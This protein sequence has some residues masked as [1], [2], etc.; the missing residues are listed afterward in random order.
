MD[1]KEEESEKKRNAISRGMGSQRVYK[2]MSVERCE[3]V[4]RGGGGVFGIGLES[5]QC[6][7]GQG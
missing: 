6:R 3:W 5:E 4:H 7:C 2:S 1:W